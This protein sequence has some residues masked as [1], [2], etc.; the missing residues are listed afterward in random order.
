MNT[1]QPCCQCGNLYHDAT[2]KHNPDGGYVECM[3]EGSLE[4][5]WGDVNCPNYIHS[6][7]G[8]WAS[9]K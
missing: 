1:P 5:K 6:E 3:A 7:L 8:G 9:G 4:N 2:T